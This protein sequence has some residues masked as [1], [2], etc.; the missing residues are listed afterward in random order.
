[1]EG[2]RDGGEKGKRDMEK[3]KVSIIII[4]EKG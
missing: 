2:G 1:M 3:I 4:N